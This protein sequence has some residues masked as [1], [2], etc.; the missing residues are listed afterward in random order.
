MFVEKPKLLLDKSACA[1]ALFPGLKRAFNTIDH[2]VLLAKL[3]QL[4]KRKKKGPRQCEA[5]PCEQNSHQSSKYNSSR[6]IHLVIF[7]TLTASAL[8]LRVNR[9][10]R[11]GA[12][13]RLMI[14]AFAWQQ[15]PFVNATKNVAHFLLEKQKT[16]SLF[17]LCWNCWNKELKVY[18]QLVKKRQ[19]CNDF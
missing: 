17:W 19:H 14:I 2:Q 6:L 13:W 8:K 5:S 1:G 16:K 11:A 7:L 18:F 12:V 3:S 10:C 4:K 15:V 9:E